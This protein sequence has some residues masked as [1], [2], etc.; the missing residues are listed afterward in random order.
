VNKPSAHDLLLTIFEG[1]HLGIV[2]LAARE[3]NEP[4][5]RRFLNRDGANALQQ[6]AF[7]KSG[8]IILV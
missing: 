1:H 4:T 3:G 2:L 6:T 8:S 5:P 7:F